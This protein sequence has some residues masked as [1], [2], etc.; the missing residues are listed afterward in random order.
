MTNRIKC[1]GKKK[2]RRQIQKSY[3]LKMGTVGTG[4]KI[5]ST[6]RPN[7]TQEIKRP[8]ENWHTKSERL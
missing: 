2:K 7:N 4:L 5:F 6:D 1:K 3:H 8:V